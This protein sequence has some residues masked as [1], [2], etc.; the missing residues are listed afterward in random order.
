[1]KG[2]SFEVAEGEIFAPLGRNG[3]GKTT[4]IEVLAGFQRA[5]GGTVRVLGLDPYT[6]RAAVRRRTGIMP[7]EAGFF[8]DLTVAQTIGTWRDFTDGPRPRDEAIGLDG[9]DGRAGTK[10]R[11]LSGGEKR[12]L[13]LA[14]ALLGRPD[15][16]FL[17]LPKRARP[18][19]RAPARS[20]RLEDRTPAGRTRLEDPAPD[21]NARLDASAPDWSARQ[22]RPAGAP[23]EP[24]RDADWL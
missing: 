8:A 20:P 2:I 11:Q 24:D 6:D 15:A 14:L 5:D 9:L 16:L 12:R 3:A 10:V 21:R 4:A 7:Q 13:D 18:E 19:D 1:M 23:D 22:E 17:D